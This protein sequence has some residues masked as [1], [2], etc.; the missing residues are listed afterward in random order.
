MTRVILVRHG[1]ST[2]NEQGLIQGRKDE[3]ILTAKGIEQALSVAR[4]LKN[5]SIDQCFSSPL[6]RARATAKA[7]VEFHG[8]EPKL[9]DSLCEI[10]LTSWEGLAHQAVRAQQPAAHAQWH[11]HPENFELDGRLPVVEL[12][13]QAQ[14]AWDDIFAHAQT[15][16]ER[17]GR[18]TLLIVAHNAINQALLCTALGLPSHAFRRFQQDNAGISV[19]SF[20][21]HGPVVLESMNQTAHNGQPF[22]RR[23]EKGGRILL[24][25]HGETDWNRA[26]RFQGQIDIPLNDQGLAQAEKARE[27]LKNTKL[28][29]AF[30]SPL[31][32]PLETC[33]AVLA[34]HGEIPLTL[35]NDLQE[36]SHGLWEGKLKAE[37]EAQFPG[38]LEQWTKTPEVVQM[39][40]GE[41]LQQVWERSLRAWQDLVEKTGDRT[42][43]VAA[44]DAINKA[45]VAGVLGLSPNSFW[46]FKQGNGAVTV[47]DYPDGPQGKPVL[48]AV[49]LTTHLGEGIF[50]CTAA[51]AL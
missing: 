37:I 2:W 26:E 36:I 41:N 42:A 33:K 23:K 16:P 35:V 40:E 22:P 39:P 11:H 51:G 38:A 21:E 4:V 45:I 50:D 31:S 13:Q 6:Q 30:S 27:F 25:R 14:Q 18:K 19:L 43:L 15:L 47:F 20:P 44:H 28:D 8:Q 7:I 29:L 1:Q 10:N 9:L 5:V 34:H 17:A 3:S 12:W 24:I 48:A 49:N 46:T 32:R